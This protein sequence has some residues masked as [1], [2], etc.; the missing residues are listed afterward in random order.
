MPSPRFRPGRHSP[1]ISRRR[2]ARRRRESRR[3]SR[4]RV[5]LG[6]DRWLH[7]L[8][9]AIRVLRKDRGFTVTAIVT[10][11][12]CLGGHAAIV[13]GV[14]RLLFHPL[15][16]PE[17]DRVLLMAN[18]YPVV[19]TRWGTSAPHRTTTIDCDTSRSSRSRRS[20]TIPG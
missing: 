3:P 20:T 17:A 19:E 12:I 15:P 1:T 18:Q 4:L 14:N 10:L 9:Q 6:I 16:V 7:D 2:P 5:Y 11:T 8:R 13:A